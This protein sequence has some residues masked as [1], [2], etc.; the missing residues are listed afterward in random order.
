MKYNYFV[1]TLESLLFLLYTHII[2]MLIY[3]YTYICGI[4]K[5][6]MNKDERSLLLKNMYLSLYCKVCVWE[7]V[8]DRTEL[9]YIDSQLLWPS[10]LCLSRSLGLLLNRRLGGPASLGHVLLPASS[11]QLVWSPNSIGGPEGAF[12][13]AVAFSTTTCLQLVWTPIRLTSCIHRVI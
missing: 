5:N 6:A 10:A 11:H 4:H 13:W 7:W 9:P 8:G 12:C 3:T 1:C 2:N